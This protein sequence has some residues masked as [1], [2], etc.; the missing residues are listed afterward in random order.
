MKKWVLILSVFFLGWQ[1]SVSAQQI[2]VSP[3]KSQ[4]MKWVQSVQPGKIKVSPDGDITSLK[5]ALQAAAPGD[6][7]L[8]KEGRYKEYDITVDQSVTILGEKNA[9]IDVEEKGWG[10]I[11]EAPDVKV[12][13]VEIHNIKK[14]FSD[15]YAAILVEGV[16]NAVI[17]DV[18]LRNGFFGIYLAN[19]FHSVVRNNTVIGEGRRES[20]SGNGIHLWSSG[21]VLVENNRITGHRDGIY[22]EFV[23]QSEISRNISEGNLRY[24]LHFMFSDQCRYEDNTFQ[25][26]GAGVAVMFTDEVDMINNKFLDNWGGSSY[27]L[28]LKEIRDSR[29]EGNLFEENTVA[30]YLEASDRIRFTQNDFIAN[31]WAIEVKSNAMN[32]EFM[33]NNFVENTF[34]VSASGS[35]HFNTFEGNYWSQYEGYDLDRDGT[36]DVP[37]RP[38]RLFNVLVNKQPASVMLLRSLLIDLL[39]AAERLM[40]VLTP[41]GIVDEQ[42]KM[43]EL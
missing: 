40:P 32:N 34:E 38:V 24:G 15:D 39:D 41:E 7:I 36:G 12:K 3:D 17:E 20:S 43:K 33:A 13:G 37:H 19:S 10:I 22:F 23:E 16:N 9:I 2:E 26:N 29:V 11:I 5:E 14:G 28:L 30:V 18:T 27:G 1:S 6:T 4:L 25:K 21:D 31:G 35:Q 8:L 42:P